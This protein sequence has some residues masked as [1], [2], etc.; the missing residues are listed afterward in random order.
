MID[1]LSANGDPKPPVLQ[2]IF[3]A[4]T[5][6]ATATALLYVGGD[7]ALNALQTVSIASGV[8]YTILLCF[9]CVA[10]WRAV[11]VEAGDLDPNGPQF[12]TGL[13]DVL[14][15]PTTESVVKV[16]LNIFAPWYSMSIAAAEVERPKGRKWTKM[17]IL[18][19]PFYTWIALLALEFFGIASGICY[20]G[21]TVLFGFFAYGT[22]IRISIREKYDI[23]G[24]MV[25]DFFAVMILYPFAAYQ[26]EHHM[27]NYR[28]RDSEEHHVQ[29]G[30]PGHCVSYDKSESCCIPLEEMEKLVDPDQRH[31]NV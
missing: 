19:I 4:L 10:L 20:V 28:G 8:P 2:R 21:W 25:E 30:K 15:T 11:K 7:K 12:T 22:G 6:G 3:W 17:L 23:H 26:M 1:C 5:E 16:F 14:S 13:L 9:M 31:T 18:A 24:N 27:K 29:N